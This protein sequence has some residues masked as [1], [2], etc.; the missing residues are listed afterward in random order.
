[1]DNGKWRI[2]PNHSQ[3]SILNF[4][5]LSQ[6]ALMP[7]FE[8]VQTSLLSAVQEVRTQPGMPPNEPF[9]TGYWTAVND[10]TMLFSDTPIWHED[11]LP[12]DVLNR[13]GGIRNSLRQ[14]VGPP[15]TEKAMSAGASGSSA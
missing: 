5:F 7:T 3:L 8:D 11:R 15:E 1:M 4:P 2:I 12:V 14:S 9:L 6:E 10:L 13:A